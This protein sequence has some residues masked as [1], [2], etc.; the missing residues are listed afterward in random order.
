MLSIKEQSE[1]ELKLNYL[2]RQ[3]EDLKNRL[4]ELNK[5]LKPMIEELKPYK[6]SFIYPL[7]IKKLRTQK[8][9]KEG[10]RQDKKS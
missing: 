3:E 5:E 4:K 10:L 9:N 1:K 8:I 6:N 7:V 2:L